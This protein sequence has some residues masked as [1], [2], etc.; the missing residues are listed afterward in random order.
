MARPFNNQ[1]QGISSAKKTFGVFLES[2]DSGDYTQNKTAKT[3][4][5]IPNKCTKS[6]AVGSQNNYLM[7]KKS[8]N[9]TIKPNCLNNVNKSNLNINLITKLNLKDIPVIQDFSDNISPCNIIY[10]SPIPSYL[11][12]NIDPKG[13]LFGKTT[14]GINNFLR[15]LEYNSPKDS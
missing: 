2:Q 5:C 7:Y 15:Y 1:F 10:P 6:I 11:Q 4:Y 3:V 9:L 14:C 12:Y 8:N 13:L